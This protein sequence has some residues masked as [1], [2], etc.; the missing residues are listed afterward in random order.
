MVADLCK[1]PLRGPDH[2]HLR[3]VPYKQFSEPAREAFRPVLIIRLQLDAQHMRRRRIQKERAVPHLF[4]EEPLVVLGG[5][6]LHSVI[7]WLVGL[8]HDV[9]GHISPARS[10]RRLG[11][12]LESPLR[13]PVIP[14]VQRH[15]RQQ[16]PHKRDPREIVSLHDHLC[17]HKD[18][19][20]PVGKRGKDLIV[21]PFP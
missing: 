17:S 9:S 18:V 8:D 15:V 7:L 13:R 21:A 6:V 4:R 3:I 11:Q 16:D 10:S 19:R 12:Q 1:G 5:R 14:C 20:L 2:Q